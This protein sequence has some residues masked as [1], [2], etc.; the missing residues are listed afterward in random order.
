MKIESIIRRT[1]GTVVELPNPHKEYRF[2]PSETDPRH[3][4]EVS[5]QSHISMLLRI[6]EG[7]RAAE[8]AE[9]LEDTNSGDDPIPLLGSVQHNPVYIIAGGDEITLGAVVEMAQ[10]DSGET[11]E[12]WNDLDDQ[13]RHGWIDQVLADLKAVVPSTAGA[14]PIPEK[15]DQ[16]DG[17]IPATE[18]V[19]QVAPE[20]DEP[21]EQ[22]VQSFAAVSEQPAPEPAAD[23]APAAQA[24]DAPAA[25]VATG[26]TEE[27]REAY[28]K[29]FNR[30]PAKSMKA[31]QVQRA[32]N[33]A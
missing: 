32:I 22:P 2:L 4:A 29:V 27:M 3:L 21:V 6:K 30:Y 19:A 1:Q 31:A 7:Y 16:P 28:K 33:E 9:E 18:P 13:D 24:T 20:K 15:D 5:E 23:P 14:P 26:V 12:A 17:F 25:Q 10:K 11:R 8:E